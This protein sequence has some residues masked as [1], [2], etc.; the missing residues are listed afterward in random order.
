MK[1]FPHL[2]PFPHLPLLALNVREDIPEAQGLIASASYNS[3]AV[4][5][6]G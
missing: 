3:A 4:G 5:T 1:L 2:A 6:H